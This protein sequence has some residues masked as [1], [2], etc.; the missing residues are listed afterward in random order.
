MY[1]DILLYMYFLLLI[2]QKQYFAILKRKVEISAEGRT[3]ERE[4]IILIVL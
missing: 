3:I 1:G 2:V 4:I